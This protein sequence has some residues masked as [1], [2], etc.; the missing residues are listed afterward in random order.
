[1]S[2]SSCFPTVSGFNLGT[3]SSSNPPALEEQLLQ[4]SKFVE[5]NAPNVS[6]AELNFLNGNFGTISAS[7]Q[8][9]VLDHKIKIWKKLEHIAIAELNLAN[10]NLINEV[11]ANTGRGFEG[12]T[13]LMK[14]Q[15]ALAEKSLQI[16]EQNL[17]VAVIDRQLVELTMKMQM[18]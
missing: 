18:L 1:M 12:L 3:F 6:A 16:V 8:L 7:A 11:R 2:F 4:K 15:V 5:R 14:Q 17:L 10:L 13:V 9:E